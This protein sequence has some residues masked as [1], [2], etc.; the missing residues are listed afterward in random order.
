MLQNQKRGTAPMLKD[1]VLGKRLGFTSMDSFLVSLPLDRGKN[2]AVHRHWEI[3][4]LCALRPLSCFEMMRL[5]L[6]GLPLHQSCPLGLARG[7]GG[8]DKLLVA[9]QVSVPP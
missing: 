1:P 9:V 2:R 8:E 3:L 6:C 7:E 5:H 4:P